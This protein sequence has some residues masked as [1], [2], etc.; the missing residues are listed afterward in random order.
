MDQLCLRHES[1]SVPSLGHFYLLI[2]I[3]HRDGDRLLQVCDSFIALLQLSLNSS[4]GQLEELVLPL[5]FNDLVLEEVFV[6]FEGG[7]AGLPMLDLLA[8]IL[9]FLRH[10]HTLLVQAVHLLIQLVDH[11]ILESVVAVFGVEFLDQ[12]L[13]LLL[14]GLNIDGVT[15]EVVVLLLLQLIVKLSVEL[16]DNGVQISLRLGHFRLEH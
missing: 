16:F 13:Q 4:N 2:D 6:L 11:F 12:R 3:T 1:V 9:L 8:E 15:F 5:G 7:R 14:L 10:L